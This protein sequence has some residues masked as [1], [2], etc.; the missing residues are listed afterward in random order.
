MKKTPLN[1]GKGF[2]SKQSKPMARSNLRKRSKKTEKLYKE[3][4]IPLVIKLLE[5]RPWCEACNA[6]AELDGKTFYRV[7]Q[8][9]EIHEKLSRGRG[10]GVGTEAF[11]DPVNLMALCHFCHSRITDNPKEA[12]QLG[13]L[14]KKT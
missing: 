6:F 5:E 3:V 1:K 12:E 13:F 11:I 9:T 2:Q 8:S 4:R 7:N 14:A 10:G